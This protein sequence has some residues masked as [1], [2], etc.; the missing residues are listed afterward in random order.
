MLVLTRKKGERIHFGE[1]IVLTV[2][3]LK[4]G[5][6]RLGIDAPADVAILRGEIRSHWQEAERLEPRPTKPR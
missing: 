3:G 5:Q 4:G 6:V 2:L 1:G